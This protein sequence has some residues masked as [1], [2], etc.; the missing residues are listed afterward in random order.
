MPHPLE[1]AFEGV[2][3]SLC[4]LEFEIHRPLYDWVLDA[5]GYRFPNRPQQTEFSRLNLTYTVMSKRKLLQLVREGY[6]NGWDDPRMPTLSGMRR[7][8]T[9]R[10]PSR[11]LRLDGRS[12]QI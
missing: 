6:V 1:D 12:D 4:T 5:L 3:H 7:R 9:R 8:G 11:P 2:T 10:R